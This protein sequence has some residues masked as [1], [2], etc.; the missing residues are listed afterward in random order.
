V[1]STLCNLDLSTSD[2]CDLAAL[3]YAVAHP[4]V[5]TLSLDVTENI[6][7]ITRECPTRPCYMASV[8]VAVPMAES[9]QKNEAEDVEAAVVGAREEEEK[10]MKPMGERG[11]TAATAAVAAGAY[12]YTA[13]INSNRDTTVKHE[14]PTRVAPCL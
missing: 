6:S 13:R 14:D 1:N 2:T 8:R 3:E 10:P 12:V 9:S 7:S 5:F 11:V 4:A